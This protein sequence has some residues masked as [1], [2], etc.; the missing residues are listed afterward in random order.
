MNATLRNP[1]GE[2]VGTIP[3]AHMENVLADLCELQRGQIAELDAQYR[4]LVQK[5]EAAVSL[6]AQQ[7]EALDRLIKIIEGHAGEEHLPPT[8]AL[9]DVPV[10]IPPTK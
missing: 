5:Y 10:D 8:G 4:A 9:F 3:V 7:K 2:T 1:R 6:C